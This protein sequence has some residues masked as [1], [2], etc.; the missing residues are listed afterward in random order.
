MANR[1]LR[2]RL[3]RCKTKDYI[4]SL[5]FNWLEEWTKEQKRYAVLAQK[6]LKDNDENNLYATYRKMKRLEEQ[7]NNSLDKVVI[8][9]LIKKIPDSSKVKV[10]ASTYVKEQIIMN[11][12]IKE[13][14]FKPNKDKDKLKFLLESSY[15]YADLRCKILT[16]I[17]NALLAQIPEQNCEKTKEPK[18]V[19]VYRIHK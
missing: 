8:D 18:K 19:K 14:I 4:S 16:G 7:K 17:F 5:I 6:N 12:K 9:E 10:D 11:K 1:S 3:K 13:E 2:D 15:E